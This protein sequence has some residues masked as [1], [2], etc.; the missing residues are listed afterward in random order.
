MFGDEIDAIMEFD[1]LTARK[2][3]DLKSVKIYAN[4]ALRDAA[5]DPDAAVKSIK[6]E[7]KHRLVELERA[8]RLL[9]AQR[10]EQR[11]R[12]DIE[13][14]EATGSCQGIENYSRYLT[15]G[16]PANRPPTLSNT[17]RTTRRSSS[18]TK[19]M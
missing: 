7:L 6:E 2:T 1:P 4:S 16:N 14:L 19:A 12:Y 15:G 13:M 11:T 3:G 5:P 17:F 9:E 10:L 18:S 8:G